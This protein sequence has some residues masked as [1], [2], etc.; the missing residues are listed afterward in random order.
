MPVDGNN[1][2]P[3]N[4]WKKLSGGGP[5]SRGRGRQMARGG[6]PAAPRGRQMARGGR[7]AHITSPGSGTGE[8]YVPQ[9]QHQMAVAGRHGRNTPGQHM[10]TSG[11]SQSHYHRMGVGA[12]GPRHSPNSHSHTVNPVSEMTGMTGQTWPNHGHTVASPTGGPPSGKHFHS[13]ESGQSPYRRG[14]KM[15]TGGNVRNHKSG[16]K[17]AAG[18]NLHGRQPRKMQ[19]GG[20]TCPP[21]Q[22]MMPDGTCMHG[23]YHGATSGGGGYRKG[24]RPGRKFAQ[25]GHMHAMSQTVQDHMHFASNGQGSVA[26]S[27]AYSQDIN[28]GYNII[29]PNYTTTQ[30]GGHGHR[31]AALPGN[32]GFK[33]GGSTAARRGNP[34]RMARGGRSAPRGKAMARGGNVKRR[35]GGNIR[36]RK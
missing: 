23:A 33:N 2:R 29:G 1:K 17:F 5:T 36:R 34:K 11:E 12:H 31:A 16:K 20:N 6:R 24:G 25:G 13:M 8:N 35:R 28:G 10:H 19:M 15:T 30:G 26:T 32:R 22:H 9:H 21:G 14:G 18:G 3:V 27:Q 4:L 7:H